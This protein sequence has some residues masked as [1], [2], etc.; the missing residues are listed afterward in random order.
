[1]GGAVVELRITPPRFLEPEPLHLRLREAIEAAEQGLRKLR[2]RLG[3][4]TQRLS[5]DL[6]DGHLSLSHTADC[7]G[8]ILRPDNTAPAHR[9]ALGRRALPSARASPP[10][11]GRPNQARTHP[12][13]STRR[14]MRDRTVPQD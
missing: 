2:P 7:P 8:P 13:L 12:T 11:V 6:L 3:I 14:S 5:P 1:M 4:E 9:P 10:R